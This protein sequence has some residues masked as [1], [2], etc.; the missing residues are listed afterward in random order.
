MNFKF[1]FAMFASFLSVVAVDSGVKVALI[2][3][4]ASILSPLLLSYL[5]PRER[6][7]EKLEDYRRQDEVAE[8]V[9]KAASDLEAANAKIAAV[10]KA[11]SIKH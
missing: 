10:L 7:H 11:K 3:A 1:L 5:T 2:V 9:K 6:R 4:A 8:R